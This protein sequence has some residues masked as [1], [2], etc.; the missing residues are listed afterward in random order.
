MTSPFKNT[1]QFSH[2]NLKKVLSYDPDTGLFVWLIRCSPQKNVGDIAGCVNL[3]GYIQVRVLGKLCY[4]HR[5]AWFYMTGEWPQQLDHENCIKSDNRWS[6]IRLA[7]FA[8]NNY[9]KKRQANNTS[10]YKGVHFHRKTGMWRATIGENGNFRHI[11][12]FWD[13]EE[14]Y[15]AYCEAL[16]QIANS[17]ARTA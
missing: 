12:L 8:Q 5:L 3:D 11:G 4:G 10:G 14:A 17:F 15:K 9:N 6:N 2:E 7:T 1:L 16:M 13:K